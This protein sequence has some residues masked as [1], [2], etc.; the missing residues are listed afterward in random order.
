MLLWRCELVSYLTKIPRI[1][2]AILE[3]YASLVPFPISL[4]WSNLAGMD[5][6]KCSG[7]DS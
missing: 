7:G 1:A 3:V 5:R 6:C 2:A 4:I